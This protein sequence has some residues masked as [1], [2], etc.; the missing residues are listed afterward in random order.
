[1]L[2][3]SRLIDIL[4]TMRLD[5]QQRQLPRC[6]LVL[7]AC[8]SVL[9]ARVAEA[10]WTV[11]EALVDGEMV[12]VEIWSNRNVPGELAAGAID[13]YTRLHRLTDV[14]DPRSEISHV[15]DN[16][17]AQAVDIGAELFVFVDLALG[18]AERTSGA[19]DPTSLAPG[20]SLNRLSRDNDRAP[21][22]Y[23]SVIL[24]RQQSTI[25]FAV[26]Q[27]RFD[28]RALATAYALAAAAEWLRMRGVENG[29][30]RTRGIASYIGDRR[31]ESWS[32][33]VSA[34][35]LQRI[36]R[37]SMTDAAIASVGA[38]IIHNDRPG[39]LSPPRNFFRFR[40]NS[41]DQYS[42]G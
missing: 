13:E 37:L 33:G 35:G 23:R 32:H 22:D 7:V 40:P 17:A 16:A 25:H 42:R 5:P 31:G 8:A 19:F 30:L 34:P 11:A 6:A 1:M 3:P 41:N 38:V 10:R 18:I 39:H 21:L 15:N 14:T 12:T 24:D 28:S 27:L 4:K 20:F 2:E 36:V 9:A 29:R 26:P